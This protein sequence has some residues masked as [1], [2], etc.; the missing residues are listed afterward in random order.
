MALLF[1][2]NGAGWLVR[3]WNTST[4]HPVCRMIQHKVVEAIWIQIYLS[5]LVACAIFLFIEGGDIVF[6][7]EIW[8]FK[9][10]NMGREL[11]IA[12]EFIYDSARKMMAITGLHNQYEINSILYTGAVGIERLQKYICVWN[13][14]I[15][16][17]SSPCRSAF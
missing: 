11:E 7:D 9:S 1:A 5:F 15:R 13:N 12:G 6:V 2:G 8:D 17:I 10:I 16:P 3:V 4:C 14:I